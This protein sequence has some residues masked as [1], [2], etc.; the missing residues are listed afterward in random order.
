MTAGDGEDVAEASCAKVVPPDDARGA[1]G[2]D[3]GFAAPP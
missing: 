2:E 3:P 1:A